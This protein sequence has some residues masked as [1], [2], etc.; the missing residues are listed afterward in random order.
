MGARVGWMLS[1]STSSIVAFTHTLTLSLVGEGTGPVVSPLLP[2]LKRLSA[3]DH[4]HLS[5]DHIGIA[6]AQHCDDV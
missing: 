4:D 5:A 1:S 2:E 6:A 3:I